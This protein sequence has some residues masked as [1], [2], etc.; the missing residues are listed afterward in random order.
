MN[1]IKYILLLISCFTFGQSNG[2]NDE[3]LD[4]TLNKDSLII[5]FET[6]HNLIN[7][8]H[9]G[10]FMFCNENDFEKCYDSLKSSIKTDLS[11]LDYYKKTSV[12]MAKIKDGHTAIDR[13][14]IRNL[15][16]NR[17]VIPLTIFKIKDGYF[18][19]GFTA[20]YAINKQRKGE[21]YYCPTF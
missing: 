20:N 18:W 3:L 15:L 16:N 17:L 4:K 11:I 8:I 1:Q 5:E 10:Q 2:I 14:I 13:G 21:K 6:L 12:L 7:I 19:V 9:P